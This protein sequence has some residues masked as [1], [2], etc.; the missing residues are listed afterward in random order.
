MNANGN[1]SQGER[2]PRFIRRSRVL[3]A[4][5]IRTPKESSNHYRGLTSKICTLARRLETCEQ[6]FKYI[7]SRP[8]CDRTQSKKFGRFSGLGKSLLQLL[9][10][11]LLILIAIA[12]FVWWDASKNRGS[13][14]GYW[15]EY[16]RVSNALAS[17][18]EVKIKS[19]LRTTTTSHWKNSIRSGNKWTFN[20]V[21]FHRRRCNPKNATSS[22]DRSPEETPRG[23]TDFRSHEQGQRGVRQKVTSLQKNN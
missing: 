3:K 7:A 8:G 5:A 14:S 10:V 13:E 6:H 22:N 18:P 21:V 9:G 15:G 16:N 19:R 12:V 17:L 20:L 23:C 4:N 11:L 1:Q 2:S